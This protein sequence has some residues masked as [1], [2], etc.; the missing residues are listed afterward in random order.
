MSEEGSK[1]IKIISW[2]L[3]IVS[4]LSIISNVLA[5]G[6]CMV[7]GENIGYRQEYFWDLAFWTA[8]FAFFQNGFFDLIR[9]ASYELQK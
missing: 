9:E 4:I 6:Y 2:T 5:L 3:L 8:L 7:T 1:D